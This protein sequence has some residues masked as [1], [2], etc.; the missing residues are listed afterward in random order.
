MDASWGKLITTI[1]L[2]GALLAYLVWNFTGD[3]KADIK[4]IRYD[5]GTHVIQS[6]LPNQDIQKF[7]Q[8][9]CVNTSKNSQEREQCLR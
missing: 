4:S 7:L 9:I 2:P 8:R 3:V 1:G 6:Q 5:L